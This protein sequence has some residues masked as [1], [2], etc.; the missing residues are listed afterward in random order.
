MVIARDTQPLTADDAAI[1][2]ALEDA[3]LPALLPA[4]AQAT[5][6]LSLLREELRP[7]GMAPA[8]AQ[9]GMTPQQQEQAKALA[10]D[11]LRRL[12]DRPAHGDGRPDEENVRR[13]AAWMT[14]SDAAQD[15]MP[16]LLEELAPF[17]EDPRAP[18]W[19]YDGKTPFLTAIVGAGMSGILAA[20][21]L[22]QAGVPF[23]VIEKNEDVGGT[24][25]ENT[26]PGARV[27]V[28]NAFYSYSFAQKIDWPKFFSPQ[29]VLLDYFR[30]C[31][32][33]Y[34][35]R[36]SIRFRTE[37]LSITFDEARCSW[38]LRLRTPDGG[39]ETLD[40]QAVISA[41][42]Q[43]NRP[44][45][46]KIAGMNTFEGPSF[47]S[48]RW[49][50]ETDLADKRV[51]VIGTGASAVQFVPEIAP[52]VAQ[53]DVFQRTP[54]WFVPVPHYHDD[55][56]AGLRWLFEHVPHYM[57]WYRFW[58][59]WTTTEGLLPSAT[60]DEGWTDFSRAVGVANDQLR[61]LLTA[62]LQ[63]QYADRPD[64]FE[65][66]LPQYPPASK[67]VVLDNGAWAE[68]MKRDNV[69]LITEPID[70]ITPRGVRT[71]DGTEHAA[72]VLIYGTGFQASHFLTPMRVT[73][74]GGVD[75][76]AQWG[77]DARA[78]LGITVPNFPS[79]FM[80]YG[81]N[82]NI[83]VNGSIIYFSE[84]EVQ[85]IVGCLRLLLEDGHRAL[86]CKPDVHDA[87]NARIDAGNLKMAWGVSSVNTWYKS[88]SG[89]VA[90]NWPFNLIEYWQQTRE[91]NPD[92]YVF[93]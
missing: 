38:R 27:D 10:L 37:V 91:P 17:G 85:Y 26:Y 61:M 54:A 48:A 82:T 70:E 6:D 9:G 22:K 16:L 93:L 78:Y 41:V 87:Y 43:L 47:H 46:P 35:V 12:R 59:F 75:L 4:L 53:L 66:A 72:D 73:G 2:A 92:D 68:A 29:A 44:N 28:S 67:R 55:V 23:V 65:K 71:K 60:V 20:I 64:L 83:V 15:Y 36:G 57:H 24:W 32:D 69:H 77:G 13:I 86:D 58:L 31:A 33:E 39:E 25:F 5:G 79:F 80:M 18:A 81:P 51:A 76:N 45:M 1:R 8:V 89:R 88:E 30:T 14:G 34:G 56:P 19:R 49:D 21:R 62:W 7:P 84:C 63:A 50:H 42:G 52:R 40:A 74:R 90:Q 3:F 11:A